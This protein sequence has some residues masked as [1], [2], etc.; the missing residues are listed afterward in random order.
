[1]LL[2]GANDGEQTNQ[3]NA[4]N[5]FASTNPKKKLFGKFND[6]SSKKDRLNDLLQKVEEY[7]RFIL[8]QNINAHNANLRKKNAGD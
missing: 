1:M 7:S 3:N 2:E 5:N 6:G 8:R 4:L